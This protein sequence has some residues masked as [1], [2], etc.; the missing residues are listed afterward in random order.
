MIAQVDAGEN[1]AKVCQLYYS[2]NGDEEEVST[3]FLLFI[4]NNDKETE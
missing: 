4:K 3:C 2:G 1:S